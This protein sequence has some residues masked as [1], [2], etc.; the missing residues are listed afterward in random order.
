MFPPHTPREAAA[1]RGPK[2]VSRLSVLLVTTALLVGSAAQGLQAAETK[3]IPDLAD[4]T[5]I[6]LEAGSFNLGR[7]P[8]A[9]EADESPETKVT[10]T[11]PFWLA[12]TEVTVGQW[13]KFAETAGYKTEPEK[14]G[15]GL[16]VQVFNGARS[17]Y[18]YQ[19]G[20][21]WSNPGKGVAT[22]EKHP[23]VGVDWADTQAFCAWL[24]A[25]ERAAGRLPVGYVYSLPTEAQWEYAAKAGT[26]ANE[27]APNSDQ[28]AWH[29]GNS[30]KM[31]H[32]VA[33]LKANPWGFYDMIG[34][35]WEWCQDCYGKFPGGEVTDYYGKEPADGTKPIRNIRGNSFSGSGQ[36]GTNL[37]NRWGNIPGGDH[38][39]TR[40]FRLA[41]VPER[42]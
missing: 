32:A 20:T 13:R 19:P 14:T 36:N 26:G 16:Y 8:G 33:S 15:A 9:S 6:K 21:S 38:R 4:L 22:S 2:S 10:F 17:S 37:T 18:E 25:R 39:T 28:V 34:N 31:A 40:G 7:P 29:L 30:E 11:Q 27:S 42:K 3:V 23:V 5:L 12:A 24:T 1:S 41:L 35:V